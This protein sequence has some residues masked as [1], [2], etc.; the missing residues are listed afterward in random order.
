MTTQAAWPA[1]KDKRIASELIF[2]SRYQGATSFVY[3]NICLSGGL[4]LWIS[5]YLFSFVLFTLLEPSDV[6][7]NCPRARQG[8]WNLKTIL[9]IK[10]SCINNYYILCI[11]RFPT[12][13]MVVG[14]NQSTQLTM[15]VVYGSD[16]SAVYFQNCCKLCQVIVW[17]NHASW[18]ISAPPLAALCKCASSMH[19]ILMQWL[20]GFERTHRVKFLPLPV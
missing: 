9:E 19:T 2:Q 18:F 10:S 4:I 8:P 12:T 16:G 7:S 15:E 5:Y 3:D 13:Y 14:R 1:N 6:G 11:S 20:A 17:A